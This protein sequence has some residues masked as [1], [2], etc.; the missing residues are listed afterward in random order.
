MEK[1]PCH[2]IG[3]MGDWWRIFTFIHDWFVYGINVGQ[4]SLFPPILQTN[5]DM[6]LGFQK[7]PPEVRYDWIHQKNIPSRHQFT[8]W[9]YDWK[10]WDLSFPDLSWQMMVVWFTSHTMPRHQNQAEQLILWKF[11]C[12][13]SCFHNMIVCSNIGRNLNI[14]FDVFFKNPNS[15]RPKQQIPGDWKWAFFSGNV[16]C[17]QW[18]KNTTFP[19][20]H[21]L[22]L[23][24]EWCHGSKLSDCRGQF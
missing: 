13:Q 2:L 4:V 11:W 12:Q 3:S 10:T 9:L 21:E 8:W 20:K 6:T 24:D 16:L 7:T 15:D 18:R 14:K 23:K 5:N 22:V 17:L 19:T 1:K